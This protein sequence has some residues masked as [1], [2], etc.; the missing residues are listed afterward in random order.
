M[1]T[2]TSRILRLLGVAGMLALP[3]SVSAQT[4][5]EGTRVEAVVTVGWGRLW[6]WQSSARFGSGLNVGGTIVVRA[7]SGLAMSAGVDRTIGLASAPTAFTT[8]LRYYF[9][10]ADRAQPYLIA[11][12]GVLRVDRRGLPAN[13]GR[14]D[15][16]DV[17]Y[18]PNLGIGLAFV[19]DH[20][21][22]PLPELQWLDGTW[23]SPLNLASTRIST[24]AGYRW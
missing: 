22:V 20:I 3:G 9:R 21:A 7:K 12:F 24:G 13:S 4:A 1:A 16:I 19:D 5:A 10:S 17:G 14:A 15:A 2:K 11:G 8:N 6:R 23:R 18:G